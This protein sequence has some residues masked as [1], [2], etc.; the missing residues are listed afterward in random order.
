MSPL[1]ISKN[2]PHPG[3]HIGGTELQEAAFVKLDVKDGEFYLKE[4]WHFDTL[5][6]DIPDI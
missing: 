6:I 4:I 5:L 1:S 3:N 2:T